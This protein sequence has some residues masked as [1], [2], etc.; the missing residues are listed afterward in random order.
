MTEKYKQT[1]S[2][3]CE[4]IRKQALCPGQG[5]KGFR[6]CL[7]SWTEVPIQNC[8]KWPKWPK[9][10]WNGPKWSFFYPS[11]ITFGRPKRRAD[12]SLAKALAQGGSLKF[13]FGRDVLP[14]NF[15][16]VPILIP[17]FQE[18]VTHL[19]TNLSNWTNFVPNLNKIAQCFQN[20]VFKVW[21]NI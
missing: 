6:Y 10:V 18:K 8:L 11:Q 13:G 21:K 2:K 5:L 20:I 7:L 15:K 9:M 17:I 12:G 16:V 3:S 4:T 1:L 14:Q 19:C